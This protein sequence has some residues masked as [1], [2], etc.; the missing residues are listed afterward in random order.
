MGH[1]LTIESIENARELGGLKVGMQKIRQGRLL[2]TGALQKISSDDIRTLH[3]H[4]HVSVVIDFRMSFERTHCPDPIIP[5]ASN[6]FLPVMELSDLPGFDTKFEKILADSG[7]DRLEL[8][9]MSYEKGYFNDDFYARMLLSERGQKAYHD[10]FDCLLRLPDGHSVLWHCTDGKDRTGIAS[11]LILTALGAD[12][13]TIM[14]DY[15]LTNRFNEKK[16][17]QIDRRLEQQ[18]LPPELHDII[19]F[20][21][22]AVYERY[23]INARK[24][25]EEHFGSPKGYIAKA[26]GIG[27][28]ECEEL[29]QKFLI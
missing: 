19:L 18:N 2:R 23:M 5:E 16:M 14:E 27:S 11:M 4:Y 13:D 8:M 29:K 9:K 21:A 28:S 17:A 6:Y 3:D 26:L 20:G 12:W 24:A 25:M 7:A 1:A 22:G 10:F 15:L